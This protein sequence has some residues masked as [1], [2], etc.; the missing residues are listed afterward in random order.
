MYT[1]NHKF[2]WGTLAALATTLAIGACDTST[3]ETGEVVPR[4]IPDYSNVCAPETQG[5]LAAARG[6]IQTIANSHKW[7]VARSIEICNENSCAPCNG[8]QNPMLAAIRSVD[9]WGST[10]FVVAANTE[11]ATFTDPA[12]PE[13]SPFEVYFAR[14][15]AYPWRQLLMGTPLDQAGATSLSIAHGV[16]R[17]CADGS[18]SC[19]DFRIAVE[20]LDSTC[21]SLDTSMPVQL[22]GGVLTTT[23]PSADDFGFQVPLTLDLPDPASFADFMELEDW[24]DSQAHLNVSMSDVEV[25]WTHTPGQGHCATL[26]GNVDADTL[27]PIASSDTAVDTYADPNGQI[28]TVLSLQLRPANVITGAQ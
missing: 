18:M 25:S 4:F 14:A 21:Q 8:H 6:H 2:P 23:T 19:N 24:L 9:Q 26:T 7:R 17:R 10:E 16:H 20:S 15:L 1:R 3:N 13:A 12:H 22:G 5:A 28:R 11:T 27:D